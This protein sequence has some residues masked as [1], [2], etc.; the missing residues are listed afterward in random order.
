MSGRSLSC[1]AVLGALG[2]AATA[3]L[4][5]SADAESR[6]GP[7]VLYV[8][9]G[10]EQGEQAR[11]AVARRLGYSQDEVTRTE[12]L[13]EYGFG[14]ADL[15]PRGGEAALCPADVGD[16]ELIAR[17]AE[18]E[19]ALDLLEYSRAI[20]ALGPL[21]E[22]LAC[23]THP[24]EGSQL[25]RAGYVIAAIGGVTAAVGIPVWIASGDRSG[26]AFLI[27]EGGA[28]GGSVTVCGRWCSG[29]T[30]CCVASFQAARFTDQTR[31]K[32]AVNYTSSFMI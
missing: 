3:L 19:D 26:R 13:M 5:T 1:A 18:A 25:S 14:D 30:V 9:S 16:V 21:T 8:G 7:L 11:N 6:Q 31:K 2:L 27:L 24:V 22:A 15:W 29:E 10:P 20:N 23:I 17:I 12:P 4:P 28:E 32:T